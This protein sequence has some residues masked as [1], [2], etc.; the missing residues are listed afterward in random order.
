[1]Y[2]HIFKKTSIITPNHHLKLS[3]LFGSTTLLYTSAMVYNNDKFL[4]IVTSSLALAYFGKS[5]Y[6]FMKFIKK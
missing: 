6:H 3:I 1:M 4:T 2:N 5:S